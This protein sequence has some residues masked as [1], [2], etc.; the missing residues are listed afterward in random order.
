M[1]R[2]LGPAITAAFIALPEM[3]AFPL[4]GRPRAFQRGAEAGWERPRDERRA[5]RPSPPRGGGGEKPR[6]Q[7]EAR[8]RQQ[9]SWPAEEASPPAWRVEAAELGAE[10]VYG[11]NPVLAALRHGRRKV[12]RLLVQD[13]IVAERR[14][15]GAAVERAE[16]L[17][18]AA[19][20][21]VLRVDK[22][23]LN[24]VCDHRPH[25][26]L[27]ILCE[28][29]AFAPMAQMPPAAEGVPLWLALDEVSDPQNLGALLRSAY[30]LGVEGV[31]VSAKNSA[32]LSPAVSKAS[33]GAVELM[34]V[35]AAR[36][37]PKLL[38]EAR[39]K[40]WQ[41]VG[42]AME[43]S[44]EP[45]EVDR[46]RPTILV[47]GSEGRGLRTNVLRACDSLVCV[48]GGLAEDSDEAELVDSLNVSVA[49][50]ILLYALLHGRA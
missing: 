3:L 20:V 19:G 28:P 49:G 7:G 8:G 32:P 21:E 2:R 46:A 24:L 25:Q 6:W 18:A 22:H 34:E 41:V 29:L 44:V 30:F 4:G 27:A 1:S 10:F 12:H 33:A 38:E 37:L 50:G 23:R 43:N 35:F 5:P 31:L 45:H 39:H 16:A 47:L 17:A 14:K 36:N 42:A 13:S 11:V 48:P 40:G 26:G 9:E 15:D